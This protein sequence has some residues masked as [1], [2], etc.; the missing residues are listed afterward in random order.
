MEES[1]R[2]IKQR[3]YSLRY[4][5]KNRERYIERYRKRRLEMTEDEKE[6]ERAYYRML[7]ASDPERYRKYQ[8]EYYR[9]KCQNKN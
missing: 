7:R 2:K 5:Y 4:Y 8:R 9:R 3:E 6:E 1:I